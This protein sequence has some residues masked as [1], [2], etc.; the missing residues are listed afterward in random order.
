MP[1]CDD[2]EKKGD[3]KPTTHKGNLYPQCRQLCGE[4]FQDQ[5]IRIKK[6]R[7]AKKTQQLKKEKTNNK[8][9][10]ITKKAKQITTG[11]KGKETTKKTQH[12]AK[13]KHRTVNQSKHRRKK[14][15]IKPNVINLNI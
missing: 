1:A 8:G 13:Q 2:V 9:K 5:P 12:I 10:I 14:A 3:N 7:K 15:K 6:Q 11:N 4:D